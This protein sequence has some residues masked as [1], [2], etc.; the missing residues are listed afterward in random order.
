MRY[1]TRTMGTPIPPIPDN[2][3][4]RVDVRAVGT[5]EWSRDPMAWPLV[6]ALAEARPTVTH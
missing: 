1:R 3:Q 6:V 2:Y 4:L 5:E